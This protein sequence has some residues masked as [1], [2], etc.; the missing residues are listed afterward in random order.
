MANSDAPELMNVQ[1]KLSFF[2][3]QIESNSK[4]KV[5]PKPLPKRP[6]SQ[7]F[8]NGFLKSLEN[9]VSSKVGTN[10]KQEGAQ[11]NVKPRPLSQVVDKNFMMSL[12]KSLKVPDNSVPPETPVP[13]HRDQPERALNKQQDARQ[14]VSLSRSESVASLFRKPQLPQPPSPLPPQLFP[15]LFSPEVSTIQTKDREKIFQ[16]EEGEE[17]E[18]QAEGTISTDSSEDSDHDSTNSECN[19][20]NNGNDS[21]NNLLKHLFTLTLLKDVVRGAN[22]GK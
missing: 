2:K 5:A 6:L 21:K 22:Q 1:S 9:S 20:S 18:G 14:P 12:G 8:D 16:V 11:P 13:P 15:N 4:P 17:E 7:K 19:D 3:D 10:K